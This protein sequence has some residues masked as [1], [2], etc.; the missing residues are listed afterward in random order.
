MMNCQAGFVFV[1]A[2]TGRTQKGEKKEKKT[3][4]A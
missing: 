1:L 3:A 4:G 2:K